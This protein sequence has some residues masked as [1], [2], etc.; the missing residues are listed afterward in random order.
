MRIIT[1]GS[2]TL[3]LFF[4]S[5]DLPESQDGRRLSLA[6]GGK[7]VA[8][9]FCQAVGGGASNAAVG[10]AR[11]GFPVY[12]WLKIDRSWAGDLVLKTLKKEKVKTDLIDRSSSQI[13]IAAILLGKNGERTIVM[14]RAAND[15]LAF[16][17][18]VRKIM[19][20]CQWFYFADLSLCPKKEKL[21]WLKFA[22][23]HGVKTFVALSGNEY[24]KGL[25]YLDEY[26]TLSDIFIL[27]AHELADIWGGNAPD[28]DLK[29][30]NYAH[31]LK[32]PLLIVTCDVQGSYVYTPDKIY[33][34]PIFPA[35]RVD[36]TG[37]GDA[38]ASGFLGNF[39]KT[40]D[41][42]KAMAFAT[43]NAASVIS[44]L[45]TQAGL[46]KG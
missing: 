44:Q 20:R 16:T 43:R 12:C 33:Y 5:N 37:A 46:L 22:Q 30:T 2:A 36:A 31:K 41:I 34:Q 24:K 8:K 9:E 35:R 3:D 4:K 42:Q 40:N 13:T 19:K 10:L 25:N 38:Y 45:T 26:F 17:G 7:Y 14:H 15:R 1:V 39:L 27:N 21:T 29:K 11:Q 23:R 18:R 6:Y 28:L 32:L